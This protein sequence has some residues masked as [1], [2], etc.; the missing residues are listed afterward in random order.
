MNER[1]LASSATFALNGRL[2]VCAD[3][4]QL[5]VKHQIRVVSQTIVAVEKVLLKAADRLSKS[6]F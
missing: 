1:P 4:G 3:D 2:W 5:R 6:P